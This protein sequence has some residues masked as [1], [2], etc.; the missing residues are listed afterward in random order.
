MPIVIGCSTSK[1]LHILQVKIRI[2]VIIMKLENLVV[3]FLFT[4]LGEFPDSCLLGEGT[5]AL[6][7]D[8]LEI[9]L[10]TGAWPLA[11]KYRWI[12]AVPF[13]AAA[14]LGFIRTIGNGQARVRRGC[15]LPEK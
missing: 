12:G 8:P 15:S 6:W 5:P 10:R 11:A 7:L 3:I 2:P 13:D 4:E 1:S 9:I 14:R